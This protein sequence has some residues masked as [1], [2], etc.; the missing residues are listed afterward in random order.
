VLQAKKTETFATSVIVASWIDHRRLICDCY[1]F[2]ETMRTFL[3]PLLSTIFAAA[4]IAQTTPSPSPRPA[5]DG[6]IATVR[7]SA[8]TPNGSIEGFMKA[9]A[10]HK[11]WYR[12]HG[13]PDHEIFAARILIRDEKTRMQSYSEKEVMTYHIHPASNQPEPP[14]DAAYDGFV[15]LYRDNSDI[16]QQ[17]N[18]C[19]P[20]LGQ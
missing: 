6:N 8:I 11:E 2:G 12:S 13:Q 14:H 16:K 15:K 10:G 5:C 19:M 4:G 3:L 7:V 20:K 18:V 17:Y 1:H 9:V